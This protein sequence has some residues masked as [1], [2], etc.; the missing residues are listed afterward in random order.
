MS[1][2]MATEMATEMV[3]EMGMTNTRIK[4]TIDSLCEISN[5][6]PNFHIFR[7]IILFYQC[8]KRI[9]KEIKYKSRQRLCDACFPKNSRH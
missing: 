4:G 5:E 9:S 6:I 1:T 2:E 3:T 8:L 7:P